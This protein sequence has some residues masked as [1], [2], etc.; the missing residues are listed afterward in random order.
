MIAGMITP[1]SGTIISDAKRIAYVFQEPRA[2]PWKTALDNVAI[3]LLP[4]GYNYKQAKEK[5][6]EQ[7]GKMGLR[8][9]E[10]YFPAQ[11]SGGM[12][13]RVS[14][15]R[16]FAIEPDTLLLDEPFSALDI[17]LK[18]VLLDMIK[19]QLKAM[20]V[21][22]L[23]VSHMPEEVVQIANRIFMLFSKG[24]MEELPV[25]TDELFKD[26]LKNAFLRTKK[27]EGTM[28]KSTHEAAEGHSRLPE[29]NLDVS[30][31]PGHWVFAKMGKKVLRP[32]GLELTR[33]MLKE[34]DIRATDDVVEFAPGLGITA[35]MTIE[36]NPASF[37]AIEKDEAAA[38]RV[39][40][41]LTGER[42][43]CHLGM[44]EKTG[45]PAES[46]TVVYGEAMLTML[47]Y[48]KKREVISEAARILKPGGRY[49]IHEL[50]I[51]PDDIDDSL[52]K[53]IRS[54]LSSA[55]HVNANPLTAKLWQQML[56]DEGFDVQRV[57][58]QPFLL[59]E[60]KRLLQDEGLI[61]AARFAFNL[62]THGESRQR[63]LKMKNVFKKYSANLSGIAI[64]AAKQ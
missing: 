25:N 49:G 15:A 11:L 27:E 6:A 44:A 10:G 37:I 21:T 8:G 51:T 24:T 14:L 22:V 9:Y 31:M 38:K 45:L 2:L 5:A 52:Q 60:P 48:E 50:C 47:T 42:Q 56:K 7:L 19:E 41:L 53:I 30:K 26:L 40:R 12:I 1:D 33:K 20:P 35:K 57:I 29:K 64:I 46:A 43:T 13:Q 39:Q 16:A 54:E 61:G 62:L 59:L 63:I 55:M 32:G 34:L 23:Y 17:G 18:K 36:K 58:L 4:L 28:T 3:P